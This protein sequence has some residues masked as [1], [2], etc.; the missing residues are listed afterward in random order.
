MV[1]KPRGFEARSLNSERPMKEKECFGNLQRVFPLGALG[2]RE[3]PP[4]CLECPH[5]VACLKA[6]LCT[7]EGVRMRVEMVDRAAPKGMMGRLER[8]SRKKELSRL[9]GEERKRRR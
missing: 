5:R 6:A 2:L 7:P 1:Y 3:V 9:V 4:V 8:W